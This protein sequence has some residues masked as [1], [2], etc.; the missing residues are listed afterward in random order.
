M[1]DAMCYDR[2]SFFTDEQKA[3]SAPSKEQ[4]AKRNETV[5]TLLRDANESAREA[6][7]DAPAKEAAPA[8]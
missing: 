5:G 4:Q 1:E 7:A 2:K 3:K 6:P 8:K